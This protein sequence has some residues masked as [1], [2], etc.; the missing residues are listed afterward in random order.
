MN[1]ELVRL[2]TQQFH[3]VFVLTCLFGGCIL[4][5]FIGHWLREWWFDLPICT[6]CWHGHVPPGHNMCIP[7]KLEMY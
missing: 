4:G 1:P 6:R 7:C 5:C 2:A 3:T